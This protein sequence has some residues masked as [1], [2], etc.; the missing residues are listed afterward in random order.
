MSELILVV[1]CQAAPTAAGPRVALGMTAVAIPVI[2][3]TS[4]VQLALPSALPAGLGG[5]RLSFETCELAAGS[6]EPLS[7]V[8]SPADATFLHFSVRLPAPQHA[9]TAVA[10]PTATVSL[11]A[12]VPEA[13]VLSSKVADSAPD[14]TDQDRSPRRIPGWLAARTRLI[15]LQTAKTPRSGRGQ[16][17]PRATARQRPVRHQETTKKKL[18]RKIVWRAAR[19]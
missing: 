14:G 17:V 13:G 4:P 18:Q 3:G 1:L 15:A 12:T 6:F 16:G 5:L 7:P 10:D 11:P 9:F 19:N 2:A 8:Q